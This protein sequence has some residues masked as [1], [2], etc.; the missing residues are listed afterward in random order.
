MII[1]YNLL[2]IYPIFVTMKKEKYHWYCE[3]TGLASVRELPCPE[4]NKT[5]KYLI[6]V[7][8]GRYIT[9]ELRELIINRDQVCLKCG[10][11]DKLTIDHILPISKGGDN[12]PENLQTLCESCNSLKG[13]QIIDYRK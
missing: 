3:K 13:D 1:I 2:T 8:P 5:C 7:P 6:K 11:K 4:C 12:S 10:R 9:R